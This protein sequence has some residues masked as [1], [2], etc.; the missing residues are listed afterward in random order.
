MTESAPTTR[1]EGVCVS[2]VI[3]QEI[4]VEIERADTLPPAPPLAEFIANVPIAFARRHALLA[5]APATLV[6][7]SAENLPQLEVLS[8]MLGRPLRPLLAPKHAIL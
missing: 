2:D 7:A 4:P 5:M 6:M 8:R 3:D 1:F